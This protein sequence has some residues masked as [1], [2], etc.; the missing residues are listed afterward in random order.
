MT[1]PRS[2]AALAVAPIGL[3]DGHVYEAKRPK[4]VGMFEPLINDRQI[5]WIGFEEVQYD[6]P[7]VGFGRSYPR[8]SKEAFLKWA[9]R[10]ITKEMPPGEWR[11]GGGA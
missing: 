11:R 1:T 10:D 9:A 7:T 5:K 2:H 3:I 4:S 8:V 6:S